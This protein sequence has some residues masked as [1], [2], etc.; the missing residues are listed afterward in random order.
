[1]RHQSKPFGWLHFFVCRQ[2]TEVFQPCIRNAI[3]QHLCTDTQ[4]SRVT[5]FSLLY[6]MCSPTALLL[7][8]YMCTAL[9]LRCYMC[10]AL[11]LRCY[12]CTAL[13]YLPGYILS[14]G[15]CIVVMFLQ[16]LKFQE[17]I[18]LLSTVK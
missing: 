12:M 3:R 17:S 15:T 5:S 16:Y 8:C 9:L 10:T 4:A 18:I 1:M 6:Y 13:M 11:L 14:Y 7:R 2:N